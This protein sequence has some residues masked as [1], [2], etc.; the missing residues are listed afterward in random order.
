MRN[1]LVELPSVALQV[2]RGRLIEWA[3]KA[4]AD[5]LKQRAEEFTKAAQDTADGV[6]LVITL[7]NPP[8]FPQLREALKAKAV[9][10]ASLNIPDGAP[11]VKINIF[12]GYKNE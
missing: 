4:V 3:V 8:G 5:H 6:T 1:P 7:E 12:P 11:G 2:F 9:S 10:I